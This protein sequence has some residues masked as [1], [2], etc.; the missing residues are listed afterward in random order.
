MLSKHFINKD[1]KEIGLKS[2]ICLALIFLGIGTIMDFFHTEGTLCNFNEVWKMKFRLSFSEI[3][4]MKLFVIK[5][6]LFF[7]DSVFYHLMP[8]YHHKWR[9]FEK[10]RMNKTTNLI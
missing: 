4:K 8:I 3:Q 2:F 7:L 9:W 1:V 10:K 6:I 5:S